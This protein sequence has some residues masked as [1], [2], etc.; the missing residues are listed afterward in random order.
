MKISTRLVQIH[1]LQNDDVD[2]L[3]ANISYFEENLKGRIPSSWSDFPMQRI[4]TDQK[5]HFWSEEV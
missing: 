1:W 5:S 2:R 4:T 3:K